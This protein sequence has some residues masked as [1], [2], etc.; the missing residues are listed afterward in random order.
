MEMGGGGGGG[1]GVGAQNSLS[2]A[3]PFDKLSYTPIPHHPPPPH[4][5]TNITSSII[6]KFV[7]VDIL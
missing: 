7:F 5:H 2:P 6:M 4:T 1:G 3:Q